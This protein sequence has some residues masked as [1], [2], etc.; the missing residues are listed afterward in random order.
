M[1]ISHLYN[2]THQNYR[3][4]QTTFLEYLE[5]R[6]D[7][8]GTVLYQELDEFGEITF[9]YKGTIIV[10][11]AVNKKQNFCLKFKDHCIIG[12]FNTTFN[13]RALFIYKCQSDCHSYY[14][15]KARWLDLLDEY[16][17]LT[18]RIKEGMWMIYHSQFKNKLSYN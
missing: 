3:S 7:V 11:F 2:H 15:R 14:I 5:P 1:Y 12:G 4:F 8:R 6:F 10:G 17:G 13:R 9:V 18:E 16:P